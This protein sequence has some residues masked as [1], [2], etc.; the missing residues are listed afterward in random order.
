VN[1]DGFQEGY[2]QVWC[3]GAPRRHAHDDDGGTLTLIYES[4]GAEALDS[5]DN[6]CVTP[7]GGLILCEDDA[8]SDS[9]LNRNA[10]GI[11]D[12]NRL[13]GYGRDGRVFEFAVNRLNDSELAGA[14]YSPRGDILFVNILGD[15]AGTVTPYTGNEGMT[16]AITGPWRRGPL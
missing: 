16:I 13:V 7:R 6:L 3:Y 11:E 8:S 4:T 14:T 10:P 2:G 5:P 9:D 1:A 12:V 15:T